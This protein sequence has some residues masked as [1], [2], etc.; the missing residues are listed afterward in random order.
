MGNFRT[1]QFSYSFAQ[2]THL[3]AAVSI[4]A[5]GAPTIV[6]NTGM[7]ISSITRNSTG[8]YTIALSQ[9]YYALLMLKEVQISS[10]APTAPDMY[11]VTNSVTSSTAPAV[12]VQFNSAGTATDPASGTIILID[13]VLQKSSVRY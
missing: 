10:S 11:I 4:A 6:A 12:T 9:A 8:N 3:Y 1:N 13:I 5:A 7:G 2:P